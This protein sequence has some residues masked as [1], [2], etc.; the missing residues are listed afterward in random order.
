MKIKD[1][2]TSKIKLVEYLGNNVWGINFIKLSDGVMSKWNP[3]E[4]LEFTESWGGGFKN[5]WKVFEKS[6][7]VKS[8][9][10]SC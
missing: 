2:R 8:E 3:R 6:Q 7:R 9:N 10:K 5:S 4:E 1:V